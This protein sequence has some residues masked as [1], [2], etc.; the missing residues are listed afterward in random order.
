MKSYVKFAIK[1]KSNI[2][3]H[4]KRS[5][6]CANAYSPIAKQ[7]LI[8]L[9]DAKRKKKK[10]VLQKASAYIAQKVSQLIIFF[11]LQNNSSINLINIIQ[12]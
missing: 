9:C 1:K 8:E 7:R 5:P 2:L 4:L 12:I 11:D 10:K 3:L 6:A